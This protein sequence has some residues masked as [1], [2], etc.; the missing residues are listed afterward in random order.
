[1]ALVAR[2]NHLG[3]GQRDRLL[4]FCLE[5]RRYSGTGELYEAERLSANGTSG[6]PLN[7]T[8]HQA[9]GPFRSLG[10]PAAGASDKL[11]GPSE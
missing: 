11:G 9:S 1:M 5:L 6:T 8:R 7:D 3:S 4:Q 10:W 2:L